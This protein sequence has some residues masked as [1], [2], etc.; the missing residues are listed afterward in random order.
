MRRFFGSTSIFLL[1][2]VA[3]CGTGGSSGDDVDAGPGTADAP[4]SGTPDGG[5]PAGY[6]KLIG[7]SWSLTPGQI[8]TY[9]CV[10][11]QIPQ[12]MYLSGFH[13]DAPL[14]THHTVLTVKATLGANDKMGEY[15]CGAG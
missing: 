11:I 10:R 1:M 13:A 5:P 9:R 2:A 15:D 14:G 6:T 12:D 7:R 3:A 4:T 8:D